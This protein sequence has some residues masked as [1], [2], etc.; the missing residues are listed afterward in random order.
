[1]FYVSYSY[2]LLEVDC[3]N[4]IQSEGCKVSNFDVSFGLAEKVKTEELD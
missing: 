2:V 3:M 1:M 4:L